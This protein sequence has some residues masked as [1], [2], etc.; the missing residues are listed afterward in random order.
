MNEISICH[1]DLEL[2]CR[3]EPTVAQNLA[4]DDTMVRTAPETGRHS[5]RFWWGGPP[6][7]VMGFSEKANQAV[8]P[9]EFSFCTL[10]LH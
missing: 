2:L 3:S 10:F 4:F 7:V 6:A 5:L 9:D 8:D 1:S